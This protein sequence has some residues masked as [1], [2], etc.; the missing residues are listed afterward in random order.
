MEG[1][2]TPEATS[3]DPVLSCSLHLQQPAPSDGSKA[4][5]PKAPDVA[6]DKGQEE[7]PVEKKGD[8]ADNDDDGS[9]S[10]ADDGSKGK[11]GE[12]GKPKSA[13]EEDEELMNKPPPSKET[14]QKYAIH[15]ELKDELDKE[16]AKKPEA[17]W[18]VVHEDAPAQEGPGDD[19]SGDAA[20]P[21]P[22]PKGAFRPRQI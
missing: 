14:L 11:D 6:T 22:P 4:E 16:I 13:K 21:G 2:H 20:K 12:K 9:G 1:G 7:K 10:K 18:G 15:S 17:E 8:L 5:N 3:A 19:K